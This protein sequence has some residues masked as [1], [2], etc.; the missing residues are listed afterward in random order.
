MKKIKVK[1]HVLVIKGIRGKETSVMF[2]IFLSKKAMEAEHE[3]C[4]KFDK[5]FITRYE[6]SYLV[7]ELT[8]NVR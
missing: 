8:T 6:Y 5:G 1:K 2:D 7:L 4:L 3:R